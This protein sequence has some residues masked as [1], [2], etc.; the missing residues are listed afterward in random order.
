MHRAVRAT[1]F[2]ALNHCII[3]TYINNSGL[4]RLLAARARPRAL[5]RSRILA[6]RRGTGQTDLEAVEMA[7]RRLSTR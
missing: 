2:F 3:Y 1:F 6:E 5:P 7:C 4:T